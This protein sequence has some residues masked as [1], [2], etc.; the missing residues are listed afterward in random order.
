MLNLSIRGHKRRGY[1]PTWL[2][3]EHRKR[4][5]LRESKY[6]YTALRSLELPGKTIMLFLENIFLKRHLTAD[7]ATRN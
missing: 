1:T 2:T 3:R 4:K 6:N 7:C 5:S